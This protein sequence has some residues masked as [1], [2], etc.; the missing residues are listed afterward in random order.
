MRSSRQSGWETDLKNEL[1]TPANNGGKQNLA[2]VQ[3]GVEPC[4]SDES[5]EPQ[6]KVSCQVGAIGTSIGVELDAL[7]GRL[8]PGWHLA[9]AAS[10]LAEVRRSA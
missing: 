9:S 1:R 2:D 10:E 6:R 5:P 8:D 7:N 3:E 4:S